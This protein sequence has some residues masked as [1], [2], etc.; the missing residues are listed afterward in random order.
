MLDEFVCWLE[1]WLGA[2][3]RMAL[4]KSLLIQPKTILHGD[5]VNLW[6]G[7]EELDD[8]LEAG[9]IWLMSATDLDIILYIAKSH[10]VAWI[11]DFLTFPFLFN[12]FLIGNRRIGRED[13]NMFASY[14]LLHN[15]PGT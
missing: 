9:V 10:F 1:T 5:K 12:N 8:L 7:T 13:R 14:R 3:L 6:N 11:H 4:A 15:L 2:P